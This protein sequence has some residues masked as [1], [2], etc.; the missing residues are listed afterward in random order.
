MADMKRIENETREKGYGQHATPIKLDIKRKP[1]DPYEVK[2]K[3][4]VLQETI[5]SNKK[6]YGAAC[7]PKEE[8]YEAKKR[9]EMAT[10]HVETNDLPPRALAI[11]KQVAEK[12][13]KD[14]VEGDETLR[15]LIC[16][17]CPARKWGLTMFCDNGDNKPISM[18]DLVM[19]REYYNKH[20]KWKYTFDAEPVP[21]D[22]G[23]FDCYKCKE[24]K[25]SWIPRYDDVRGHY[26][27]TP[28]EFIE[29]YSRF[30]KWLESLPPED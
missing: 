10:L 21:E 9:I 16:R 15:G 2:N 26:T 29:S 11:E 23:K 7:I 1:S 13:N 17:F 24:N 30:V 20:G 28:I 27:E 5:K 25:E 8:D 18:V 22:K 4:A 19:W 14:K 12:Y 6:K 3:K